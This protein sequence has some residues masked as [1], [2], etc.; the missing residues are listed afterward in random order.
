MLQKTHWIIEKHGEFQMYY[1]AHHLGRNR[2]L[3][4]K[5]KGHEYYED[6]VNFVK[7]G[8]KLHLIQIIKACL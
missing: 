5:Y 6:T 4:D 8:I 3:R 7:N 1:Y 2:N